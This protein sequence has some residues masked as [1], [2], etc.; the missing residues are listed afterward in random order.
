MTLVEFGAPRKKSV[1]LP[2][3]FKTK[4]AMTAGGAASG[5][6]NTVPA[7]PDP[8]L[9]V[10]PYNEFPSSNTGATGNAPSA[11]V[12]S[13]ATTAKLWIVVNSVP[14][15]PRENTV[16]DAPAPPAEAVPQIRLPERVRFAQ[17]DAPSVFVAVSA[18]VAVK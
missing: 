11:F 15:V 17:G 5:R 14:S 9:N 3:E 10:V 6:L 18:S 2:F 12:P 8:P 13:F 16:P 4:F 7:A 1:R